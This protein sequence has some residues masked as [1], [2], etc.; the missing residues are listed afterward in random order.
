MRAADRVRTFDRSVKISLDRFIKEDRPQA[1]ARAATR[2]TEDALRQNES[3]LGF[4]PDYERFVDG[5]RGAPFTAIRFGGRALVRF[6]VEQGLAN[7]MVEDV[8]ALLI[9]NSPRGPAKDTGKR[10]PHYADAFIVLAD[11]KRIR[12][13]FVVPPD[14][15]E[16]VLVNP[17]PYARKIEG[18]G[19]LKPLSAQRPNGVVE[20][21][22]RQARR[23]WRQFAFAY[24]FK[25]VARF[26]AAGNTTAG[27]RRNR[28]T[29]TTAA[30]LT[31]AASFPAIFI[32][33]R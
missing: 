15:Q 13:P 10:G 14:F 29:S 7:Q 21:T 6:D 28:R 12:P 32:S 25:P 24:G 17:R 18:V 22:M 20:E 31:R 19:N 9:A 27:A 11:D 23:K 1:F 3:V 30:S 26:Y 4:E 16:L 2:I 33:R 8:Y 5:V